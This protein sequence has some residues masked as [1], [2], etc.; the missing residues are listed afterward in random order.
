M[1]PQSSDIV[2]EPP[3]ELLRELFWDQEFGRLRWPRDGESIIGRVLQQG[4][5]DAIG[6]LRRTAGHE[7]IADWILRC[8][9]RGLNPP[10]LR[11]WEMVLG[12]PAGEVD[13]FIAE[14]GNLP[15]HPA[16]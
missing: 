8:R 14:R 12:L 7:A 4:G 5:D 13:A 16:F 9:G 2:Q 3:P 6:W 10:R 11:F 15:T 1:R